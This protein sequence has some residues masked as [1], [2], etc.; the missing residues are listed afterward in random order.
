[1]GAGRPNPIGAPKTCAVEP[2]VTTTGTVAPTE[3]EK[4]GGTIFPE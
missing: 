2:M 4:G 1:M 3:G